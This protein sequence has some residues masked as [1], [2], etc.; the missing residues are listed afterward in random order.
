MSLFRRHRST[1]RGDAAT[2]VPSPAGVAEFVATHGWQPAAARPFDGHLEDAVHEIT[3]VMYGAPRGYAT[4]TRVRVGQT[5][6]KDAFS[7]SVNGR[8]VKVS[9]AWT[10]IQSEVH[11]APDHWRGVAVC[12]AELPSLLPLSGVYPRAFA[13]AARVRP[14]PTGN[15]AFDERFVVAAAPNEIGAMLTP[16]VQARMM[17]RDDWCFYAERYLFGC[18]NR[19]P[20]A[21]V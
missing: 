14:T 19:G 16:E 9:N 18:M 6:F 17:A 7:T 12:A 21:S 2:G 5:I 3:R 10:N 15:P 13:A 11:H 20:F 1:S 4:D 8:T